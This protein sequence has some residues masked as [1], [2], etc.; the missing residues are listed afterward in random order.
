MSGEIQTLMGALGSLGFALLFNVRGKKLLF[1]VLGGVVSWGTFLLLG[2]CLSSEMIRYLLATVV[3]TLYAELMARLRKC[4]AAVFLVSG[5]IPLIPGAG[6]YNSIRFLTLGQSAAFAQTALNTIL[7][8]VAMSAG[9]LAG[10]TVIHLTKLVFGGHRE[11]K[12][13]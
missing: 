9:M 1:A 7:L 3:L 2:T 6:L 12:N 13:T 8:M 11:P 4:P 5:W 10:M